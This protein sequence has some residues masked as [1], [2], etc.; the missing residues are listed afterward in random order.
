MADARRPGRT[1]AEAARIVSGDEGSN[2]EHRMMLM[3]LV[4]TGSLKGVVDVKDAMDFRRGVKE[5]EFK[6]GEMIQGGLFAQL[7]TTEDFEA[8]RNERKI[9]VE[10]PALPDCLASDSRVPNTFE[11]AVRCENSDVWR[12]AI[13][14]EFR[15]FTESGTFAEV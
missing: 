3:S 1:R 15:G 2:L 14:Q 5:E 4:D 13:D 8:L 7:A 12:N 6:E 11:E 9:D 10:E